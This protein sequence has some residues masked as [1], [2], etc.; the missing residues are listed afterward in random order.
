[1][2]GVED[3]NYYEEAEQSDECEDEAVV[4]WVSY[5]YTANK[6]SGEEGG[7]HVK[8]SAVSGK[9][10]GGHVKTSAATG[11]GLQQ[12]LELIDDKLRPSEIEE[13]KSIFHRKW[14]PPRNEDN[15]IAIDR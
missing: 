1:M 7:G 11:V 5:D 14:R 2:E 10:G 9:E 15:E 13:E 3:G 4:S 8:T 6:V 12:L